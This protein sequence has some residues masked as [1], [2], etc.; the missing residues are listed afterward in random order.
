[1]FYNVA[2]FTIMIAVPSDWAGLQLLSSEA[3]NILGRPSKSGWVRL[4][5]QIGNNCNHNRL[6]SIPLLRATQLNCTQPVVC[7]SVECKSWS[8][9]V[10]KELVATDKRLVVVSCNWFPYARCARADVGGHAQGAGRSWQAGT[11]GASMGQHKGRWCQQRGG[12]DLGYMW[13]ECA[14]GEAVRG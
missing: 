1:M 2:T 12:W 3:S 13:Q 4:L 8:Q 9:P 6:H 7:S 10:V 14:G 11:G 5:T